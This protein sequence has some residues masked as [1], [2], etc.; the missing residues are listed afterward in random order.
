ML[1]FLESWVLDIN[2]CQDVQSYVQV[3]QGGKFMLC[4][5]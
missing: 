2:S 3:K 4:E 5:V 1:Q